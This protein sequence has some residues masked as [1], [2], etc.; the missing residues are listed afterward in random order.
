M[1][2]FPDLGTHTL[3][4]SGPH[5]RAIGW[6]SASYPFPTG[7]TPPE[8]LARIKQFCRRSDEGLDALSW[9]LFRGVHECELCRSFRRGGNVGVPA[10]E[11]LYVF[12]DMLAHYVKVHRYAPPA[13]FVAAVMVAP[14]PGTPEYHEAV[15]AFREYEQR[16]RA[17]QSR[18]A[19]PDGAPDRGGIE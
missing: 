12:P 18:H 17:G 14:L 19:E 4:A 1:G 7:D 16:R 11:L 3:I 5:V 13:K 2:W 8:V 9:G 6:L 15:A 10:G